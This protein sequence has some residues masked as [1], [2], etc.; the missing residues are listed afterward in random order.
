MSQRLWGCFGL[1]AATRPDFHWVRK[2]FVIRDILARLVSL[3]GGIGRRERT[4]SRTEGSTEIRAFAGLR[5]FPPRVRSRL[6]DTESVFDWCLTC[7]DD[8][9]F[10]AAR[11]TF[12]AR[13]AFW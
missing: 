3:T 1:E 9:R 12:V 11:R 4:D 13:Q 2:D 10:F 7:S 8:M 5:K 6:A